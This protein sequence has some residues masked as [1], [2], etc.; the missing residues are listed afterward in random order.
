M[1]TLLKVFA[2]CSEP[3]T[4]KLML[5]SHPLVN[6]STKEDSPSDPE[7]QNLSQVVWVERI[8]V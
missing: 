4:M 7:L 2:K 1:S 8:N 3:T 6:S 5:L